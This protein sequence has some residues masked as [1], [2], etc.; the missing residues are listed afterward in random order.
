MSWTLRGLVAIYPVIILCHLC[1]VLLHIPVWQKWT[2]QQLH[3]R[4]VIMFGAVIKRKTTH[5]WTCLHCGMPVWLLSFNARDTAMME[6]SRTPELNAVL[7]WLF[8]GLLQS[9]MYPYI[10]PIWMMNWRRPV[11]TKIVT[12]VRRI[13]P[14]NWKTAIATVAVTI[15]AAVGIV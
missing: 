1:L 8:G 11:T 14:W 15:A 9:W 3:Q 13:R 7:W 4:N 5:C 6:S 2:C 10:V 12:A